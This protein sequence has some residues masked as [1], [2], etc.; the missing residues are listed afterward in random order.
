M[1]DS[2]FECV[3]DIR[4]SL[5]EC[6]LWSV[7]DSALYWVDINAPAINRFDPAT[8]S[9]VAMPMP[10]S[11][12]SFALRK[13]GGFVA[14][15]RGGVW[16][17]DQ[18]GRL[19]RKVADAPYDPAHHRFNDGRCDR[20]GRFYVGSMNEN[21][22]ASSAALYRL[23]P[24]LSFTQVLEDMTISNGL[25]FSPDGR[26]MYHADT[27]THVVKAFDY[28][29]DTAAMTQ[30]REFIRFTGETDRPDG[31]TVDAEGCYWSAFFRGGKVVRISPQGRLVAEYPVPA[32]CPTMCALGGPRMT[33][34]FVTSARVNRAE[35]ELIRLPQSGSIFALEV[36]VPGVPEPRFPG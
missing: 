2:P 32:M 20:Q 1:T 15:L 8:G 22:D 33:T 6:A 3:L 18:D 11:V 35:E 36:D 25:A 28:D 21:R 16:L 23:D 26:V 30:R 10:E 19:E 17:V 13:G 4:A 14:A 5:G 29:P 27:P 24:D 34:L 12:G 7:E 31:A 9:N